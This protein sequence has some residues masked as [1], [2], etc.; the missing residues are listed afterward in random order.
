MTN[1]PE[2]DL[3]ETVYDHYTVTLSKGPLFDEDVIHTHVADDAEDATG[4]IVGLRDN[5]A[6]RA[7]VT[8]QSD[9][10]DGA[11]KLYGLAPGGVV[12]LIQVVPTLTTPVA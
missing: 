5:Y 6:D 3:E 2:L 4:L 9:K 10:V 1:Q 7:N 8:W 11:G 12:Y